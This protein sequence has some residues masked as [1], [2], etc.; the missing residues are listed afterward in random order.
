MFE[1]QLPEYNMV[2]LP[3]CGQSLLPH[4]VYTTPPESP[5]T[6]CAP[7]GP[8]APRF[9]GGPEEIKYILDD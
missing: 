9:P 7:L 5:F 3:D 6:P 1:N 8:G 2:I 4:R